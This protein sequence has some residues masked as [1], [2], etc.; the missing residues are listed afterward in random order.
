[1]SIEKM[2]AYKYGELTAAAQSLA[3][4]VKREIRL[5]ADGP[6]AWIYIQANTLLELIEDQ[7]KRG[8]E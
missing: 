6:E 3:N 1:M 2:Y 8:N 4:A 5:S 7:R